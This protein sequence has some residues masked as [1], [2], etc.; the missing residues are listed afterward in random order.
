MFNCTIKLISFV[1]SKKKKYIFIILF[2][3]VVKYGSEI[4]HVVEMRL[5]CMA[6]GFTIV[7]IV[8]GSIV[9]ESLRADKDVH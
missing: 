2:S 1:A 7:D 9:T 6:P 8:T 5:L 3:Q 4:I